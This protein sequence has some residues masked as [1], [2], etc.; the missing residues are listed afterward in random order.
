MRVDMPGVER[1]AG[2]SDTAK[3]WLESAEQLT[4]YSRPEK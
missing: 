3:D 1:D 2:D 4:I